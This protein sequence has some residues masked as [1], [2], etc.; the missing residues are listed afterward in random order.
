MSQPI[1][2]VVVTPHVCA[3]PAK[4]LEFG[5]E[6]KNDELGSKVRQTNWEMEGNKVNKHKC[7]NCYAITI[8]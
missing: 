7:T 8:V 6:A 3:L 5:W 2:K 4:D 1:G